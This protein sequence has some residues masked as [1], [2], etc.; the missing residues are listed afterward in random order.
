MS[1]HHPAGAHE[2]GAAADATIVCRRADGPA[3]RA[4]HYAIRHRVF[5]EEQS[6]F[7]ESDLDAHDDIHDG[8]EAVI[9]LIGYHDG[10]PAGSVR[11]YEID[12]SAGIWQGD[13]LAVLEPYRVRGI[14]APLVSCAVA[15]AG[16]IGGRTMMAHIQLQN[17]SFFRRL[18][19]RTSGGIEIYAGLPHQ[20]MSIELP[21]RNDG[22]RIVRRLG[23]GISAGVL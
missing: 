20:P 7:A 14:G 21:S 8:K 10:V 13:R 15:T 16:A 22:M 17:I 11:L 18:G 12:S 19:W 2:Y 23:E 4:S 3:E 1:L 6:I 9:L 5:V